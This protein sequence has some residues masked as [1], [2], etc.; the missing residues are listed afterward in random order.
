[1]SEAQVAQ[2]YPDLTL[3]P[4]TSAVAVN[5]QPKAWYVLGVFRPRKAGRFETQ[6]ITVQ[7]DCDGTQGSRTYGDV[8]VLFA[9]R[10]RGPE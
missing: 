5:G 1:M 7:Y 10:V 4:V 6:G 3:A 8:V 9:T 2:S